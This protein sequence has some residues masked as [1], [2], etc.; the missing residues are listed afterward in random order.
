MVG[1]RAAE[2]V[3]AAE[4]GVGPGV[5]EGVGGERA[6]SAG[7]GVEDGGQ[8]GVGAVRRGAPPH[9]PLRHVQGLGD[10][11]DVRGGERLILP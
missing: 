4:V 9:R 1:G 11:T 5:F 6:A 2:G 3:R 8:V 10:R 7:K